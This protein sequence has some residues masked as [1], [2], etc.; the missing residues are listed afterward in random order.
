MAHFE[1]PAGFE[2]AIWRLQL[3]SFPLADGTIILRGAPYSERTPEGA[4][5]L[6]DRADT[7]VSSLPIAE[8]RSLDLHTRRCAPLSKRART[9][10]GLP[11]IEESEWHDHYARRRARLSRP[12]GIPS[13]SLSIL[14]KTAGYHGVPSPFLRKTE[15]PTPT[16]KGASRFQ[17]GA[18]SY[19]VHL[20]RVVKESNLCIRCWNPKSYH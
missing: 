9:P 18:R 1:V 12:A 17:G 16:P 4:I 6:A 7:L 13:R 20:P 15:I 10:S 11:S 3:Q 5:G 14:R 19:R 2:P 8:G